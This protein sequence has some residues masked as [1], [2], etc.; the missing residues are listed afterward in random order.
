MHVRKGQ[1]LSMNVI[2]I[3]ALAL[4]VL[5]I[6]SMIFMSRTSNFVTESKSCTQNGGTCVDIDESCPAGMTEKNVGNIACLD[7]QGNQLDEKKCCMTGE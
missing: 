2:I 6:L 7:N 5:V 4:L 1:G 3:A